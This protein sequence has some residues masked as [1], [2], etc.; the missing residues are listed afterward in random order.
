MLQIFIFILFIIFNIHCQYENFH[1]SES[2][3]LNICNE[4][5]HEVIPSYR[6]NN[7]Y[8]CFKNYG[9]PY[10]NNI[11]KSIILP[12]NIIQ[13]KLEFFISIFTSTIDKWDQ[14]YIQIY[15][16]DIFII[17]FQNT[18]SRDIYSTIYKKVQI[19]LTKYL[20][21][22]QIITMKIVYNSPTNE[23]YS[24]YYIDDIKFIQKMTL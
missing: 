5:S 7:Y 23:H 8:F 21:K 9:F 13:L 2:C 15:I 16:N 18:N 10:L 3:A 11:S 6:H 19:D 17:R 20:I 22:N 14:S 24:S 1:C 4:E 12:N